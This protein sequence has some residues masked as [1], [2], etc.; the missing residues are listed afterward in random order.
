MNYLCMNYMCTFC[1]SLNETIF[2]PKMCEILNFESFL[3]LKIQLNYKNW[4]GR[5]INWVSN[6]H[7]GQQHMPHLWTM[8]FGSTLFLKFQYIIGKH[9]LNIWNIILPTYILFNI[10]TPRCCTLPMMINS[11]Y[12]WFSIIH[13]YLCQYQI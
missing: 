12:I 13:H 11:F 7:L 4:F 1:C 9:K 5:R 3:L 6:S 10:W 8:H 2:R